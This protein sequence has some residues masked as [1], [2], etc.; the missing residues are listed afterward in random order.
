MQ[1]VQEERGCRRRWRMGRK[2]GLA[3]GKMDSGEKVDAAGW[4]EKV[5][6]GE[7]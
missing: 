4:R 7:K 1:E 6:E 3:R 2:E 5:N